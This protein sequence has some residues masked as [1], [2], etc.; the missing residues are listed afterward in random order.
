MSQ[1]P[2]R[3]SYRSENRT[4]IKNVLYLHASTYLATIASPSAIS[5]MFPQLKPEYHRHIHSFSNWGD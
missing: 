4:Q 3:I 5:G 2:E 1:G